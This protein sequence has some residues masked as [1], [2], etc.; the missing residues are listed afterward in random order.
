MLTPQVSIVVL[1]WAFVVRSDA[2]RMVR[3][4]LEELLQQGLAVAGWSE[5]FIP[6][7]ICS[8]NVKS[9]S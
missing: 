1:A 4:P 3:A 8:V 6:L 9:T 7:V 5:A 2:E